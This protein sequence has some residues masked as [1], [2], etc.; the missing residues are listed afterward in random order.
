MPKENYEKE[1]N[2]LIKR[3]QFEDIADALIKDVNKTLRD[4]KKKKNSKK[5]NKEKESD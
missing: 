2:Q 4:E 3:L 1:V 5:T